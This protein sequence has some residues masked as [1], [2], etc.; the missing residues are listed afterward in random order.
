VWCYIAI[1]QDTK[2]ILAWHLG[3]RTSADTQVF[4]DKLATATSGNFQI[5][6]DGFKPYHEAIAI[7]FGDCV[8]FAQIVKVFGKPEGE[9]HRYS[10]PQVIGMKKTAII[11]DPDR[12][13]SPCRTLNART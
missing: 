7:S 5:N 13:R 2:L 12:I 4:T 6:T 11:G 3:R 10:P 8:D 1:E 9:D